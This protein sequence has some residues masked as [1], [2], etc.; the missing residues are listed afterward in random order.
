MTPYIGQ[1]GPDRNDVVLRFLQ[2]L[3]N[4]A[5]LQAQTITQTQTRSPEWATAYLSSVQAL[6]AFWQR[7][8][9]DRV[10]AWQREDDRCNNE[11]GFE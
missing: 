4:W 6:C 5:N 9:A 2:D 11:A 10:S 7:T 1:H 3:A 8:L